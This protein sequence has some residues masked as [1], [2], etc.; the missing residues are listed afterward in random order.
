[1]AVERREMEEEI[2]GESFCLFVLTEVQMTH[3]TLVSDVQHPGGVLG[4][5]T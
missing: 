5:E 4:K 3:V 1:M 2:L